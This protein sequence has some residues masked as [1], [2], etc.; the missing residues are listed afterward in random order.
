MTRKYDV[1]VIGA[2]IVGL[3]HAWMAARR[4]LSVVMFDRSPRAEG[5]TVRNFGMIWPI[6]QPAGEPYDIAMRSR[7]F[8]LK[9]DEQKVVRAEQCGSIHLAHHTD[10]M[11]ILE[12]FARQR[13]HDCRIYSRDETLSA[14]EI[15]NPH[16]LR[17]GLHSP[18]ELRVDP[19]LAAGN[20][21]DWL[22]SQ[23]HVRRFFC[24]PVVRINGGDI[25]S[26]NG[27]RWS[28]E[29][30]VV[31]SGS[32]LQTLFPHVL[33]ES[34]LRLC[35]LQM[36]RTVK[37]SE[38]LRLAAHI[39][40]GLTLRHYKSFV[41]CPTLASLQRRIASERPELDQYGIHVMATQSADGSL[42]LGDSHEYGD[43]ICPFD[44]T[45]IDDLMLRELRKIIQLSDWS[46][47]E[48]WHGV[49]T[50]HPDQ[51]IFEGEPSP[52]VH[53]CVGPGGAG[54]T[55]AFGLADRFWN[56]WAGDSEND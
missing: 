4:G 40:S 55:M 37:Q 17:G 9:L 51:P 50:K 33:A 29:R 16:G 36:L 45:E 8:W 7:Q 49:Y 46:I 11:A 1:A 28:A 19:R 39:A 32:D 30:T 31:C 42:I 3:A 23:F 34:G 18:T 21:G 20:I 14:I 35:K 44:K 25:E 52:G 10:E 24:T 5:A 48:R 13:N 12:E 2:G 22:E 53:V 54:M 15:V 27:E 38:S 47:A 6:G 56:R 41:D 43:E 26:A